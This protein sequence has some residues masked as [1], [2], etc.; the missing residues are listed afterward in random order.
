MSL[1]FPDVSSLRPRC[2][3]FRSRTSLA[4]RSIDRAFC[5]VKQSHLASFGPLCQELQR[6]VKPQGQLA[7]MLDFTLGGQARQAIVEAC[8]AAG[9]Q[10]ITSRRRGLQRTM[11]FQA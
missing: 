10:Q 4:G 5:E 7:L 8:A 1:W 3:I 6:V 11:I 2:P 9:F